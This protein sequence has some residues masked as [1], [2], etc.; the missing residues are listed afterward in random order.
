MR[1]L[2]CFFHRAPFRDDRGRI[3]R[4]HGEDLLVSFL[5]HVACRQTVGKPAQIHGPEISSPGIHDMEPVIKGA[6]N[7]LKFAVTVSY[8]YFSF[9]LEEIFW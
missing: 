5:V 9:R 3:A 7:E 1:P 4:E 8:F 2:P 6:G